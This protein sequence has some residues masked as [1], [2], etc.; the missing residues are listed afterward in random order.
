MKSY[1][2]FNAFIQS[3]NKRRN[4]VCKLPNYFVSNNKKLCK[5]YKFMAEQLLVSK[6]YNYLLIKISFCAVMKYRFLSK[7]V[8]FIQQYKIEYKLSSLDFF[9]LNNSKKENIIQAIRL[10]KTEDIYQS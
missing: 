10:D 8:Y 6:L 3:R 9:T 1:S 2:I 5:F 4:T 7:K